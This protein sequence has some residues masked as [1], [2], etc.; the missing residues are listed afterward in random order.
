MFFIKNDS[1][2]FDG[3]V[4][5]FWEGK[6]YDNEQNRQDGNVYTVTVS[7]ISC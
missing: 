2:L 4:L 6:P 3:S 7:R 1:N 5:G